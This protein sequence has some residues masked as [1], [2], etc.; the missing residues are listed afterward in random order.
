M[1]A[2]IGSGEGAPSA[3]VRGLWTRVPSV[4][5][6]TWNPCRP[7]G[8]SPDR[9]AYLP[10]AAGAVAWQGGPDVAQRCPQRK[11]RSGFC[12]VWSNAAGN[13]RYDVRPHACAS[14]FHSSPCFENV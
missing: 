14:I 9:S 1:L 3:S 5:K 10:L 11:T 2:A 7:P 8:K 4:P 12:P 6:F 13:V